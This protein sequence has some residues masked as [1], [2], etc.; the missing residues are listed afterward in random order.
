[1]A[2][3]VGQFRAAMNGSGARPNQFEVIMTPPV[4]AG[5][6]IQ[7][8]SFMC[9]AAS[10]PTSTVNKIEVP[11]FGRKIQLAG[12]RIYEDWNV[13]IFNDESFNVRSSLERWQSSIASHATV[14]NSQRQ[15]GA[16]ANP[17]S[18]VGG[19]R[20]NQYGKEGRVVKTYTLVNIWP[21]VIG[22]IDLDWEQNDTIETF[23]V[24]FAMDYFV[25]GSTI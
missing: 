22:S 8:F 12:D 23:Q 15:L 21:T 5:L 9:K 7:K 24:T 18:Y 4:F 13:T 16:S 2:F 17:N 10:L 3:N 1:M 19:A 25:S 14:G 6:D 11:Y 20:V